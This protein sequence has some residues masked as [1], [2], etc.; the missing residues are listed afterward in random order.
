MG[1]ML[2]EGSEGRLRLDGFGRLWLK[3]IGQPEREHRFA[4]RNDGPGG[5]SVEAFQRHVVAALMGDR[6]AESEAGDYL[7][8]LE[9]EAAIYRSAA[10][11]AWVALDPPAPR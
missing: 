8:N 5:G 4:W 10:S 1:W 3:P 9:I 2:I 6:P 11:R 7:R